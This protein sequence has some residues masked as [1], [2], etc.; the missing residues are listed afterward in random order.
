[1][2]KRACKLRMTIFKIL[3]K[4]ESFGGFMSVLQISNAFLIPNHM[5]KTMQTSW[6]FVMITV[7]II[8]I[9]QDGSRPGKSRMM[10]RH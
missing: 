5:K 1:M 2:G 6:Y 7:S 9:F 4:W 8:C 10:R 3:Q